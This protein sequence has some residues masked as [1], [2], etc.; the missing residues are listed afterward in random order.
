MLSDYLKVDCDED[1]IDFLISEDQENWEYLA[2]SQDAAYLSTAT[3]GGF[4]GTYI[5]MYAGRE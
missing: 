1:M 5:G 4:V 2:E 3:A